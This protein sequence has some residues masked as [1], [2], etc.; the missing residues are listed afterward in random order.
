MKTDLTGKWI[1]HG[2]PLGNPHRGRIAM[3]LVQH[4]N[5]IGG[6]LRQIICANSGQSPADPEE[7]TA[8]VTGEII[9]HPQNSLV[10]LK[11]INRQDSFRAVFA[12]TYH[13]EQQTI[14]GSF[15]NTHPGGGTFVMERDP[16]Q[17]DTP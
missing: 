8:D 1:F 16:K 12:G 3:E 9:E 15:V 10:I 11:R 14:T 6:T 2:H 17:P 13:R 7:V 5:D 4:E